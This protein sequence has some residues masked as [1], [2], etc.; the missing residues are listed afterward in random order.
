MVSDAG[1]RQQLEQDVCKADRAWHIQRHLWIKDKH[2]RVVRLSP[3]K[4]AQLRL[5]NTLRYFRQLKQKVRLGILKSRKVGASTLIEGDMF[6]EVLENQYDAI[7][8]AHDKPTAKFIFSM[9]A[10]FYEHYDLPKPELQRS[11]TYEMKFRKHEGFIEVHT[12]NQYRSTA[13]RTPQYV[14]CS[15]SAWWERGVEA[16]TSLLQT[17]A[18][19]PGTTL[20][21]ETTANGQDPMFFPLW[22]MAYNNA[23]LTFTDQLQPTFKVTDVDAWNGYVPFFISVMDDEHCQEAFPGEDERYRFEQTLT[24]YEMAL[25]EQHSAP[26]E[27]LNWR[28]FAIKNRCGGDMNIYNQE[29]PETP[30][31]AFVLSGRPRLNRVVLASM[32]VEKEPAVGRLSVTEYWD[33][34][35]T[36]VPD[37]AEDLKVFTPPVQN[38]RYVIGVDVAEGKEADGV[39]DKEKAGDDSVAL[40]LDIT[41]TPWQQVATLAGKIS[42]ENLVEPL[43]LLGRWYNLAFIVIENNSVGK[44]V[45]ITIPKPPFTYPLAKLYHKDDWNEE[46]RRMQREV[47]WRTHSGSK[48]LLVGWLAD[49][50]EQKSVILRDE[51]TVR[52][53]MRF[54]RKGTKVEGA[55][56]SHDDHPMALG[57]A[58]IG[59]RSSPRFDTLHLPGPIH[60]LPTTTDRGGSRSSITGY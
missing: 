46:K 49:A 14:H 26:L 32:P 56:G 57:L 3:L 19:L 17:V 30:E 8:I 35:I 45:A 10:R 37:P 41:T 60:R 21:H 36:F 25:R 50:I 24:D 27:Y 54:V 28:R 33:K 42:E 53:C 20:I 58:I 29:Y 18:D 31:L 59:A 4:R 48:S 55:A 5:L 2:G 15:E 11:S 13:G 51:E 22:E 40:V 16:S 39:L 34:Q 52:Q 7:V 47:G 12:A 1:L 43:T 9:C 38:H 23:R 6:L 44:H